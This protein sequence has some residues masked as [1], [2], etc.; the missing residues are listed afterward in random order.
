[1]SDASNGSM[2]QDF[3]PA[4]GV[5]V[6]MHQRPANLADVNIRTLSAAQRALLVIDGTVTQFLQAY[7]LEPVIVERLQ[8]QQGESTAFDAQ[9][10]QCAPGEPLLRR[11]VILKGVNSGRLFAWADSTIL[12]GRLSA[13]M[14]RGLVD[15]PAGLGKIIIDS[16]LET[17]REGLW[18]G[19]EQ[20]DSG[21]LPEN[22]T[23]PRWLSRSYRIF[24]GG[25][26]LMRVTERFP[27]SM[28]D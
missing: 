11:T 16:G 1:M 7:F 5:F 10:M 8:Q 24:A 3:D 26:P 14:R 25:Q 18:F 13:E 17:R 2:A 21:A 19:L 12:P 27:C 28:P 20:V 9:W 23:E 4:R 6:A 22:I 15:E